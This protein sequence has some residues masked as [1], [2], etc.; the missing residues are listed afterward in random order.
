[1]AESKKKKIVSADTGKEVEAGSL[2]GKGN[3]KQAAP[4]GNATGLRIGA[5]A[6]WL[7]AIVNLVAGACANVFGRAKK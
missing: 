3:Y 2:K 1:M 7:V 6:L 4:V 5:V